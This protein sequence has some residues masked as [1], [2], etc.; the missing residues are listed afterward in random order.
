MIQIFLVQIFLYHSFTD[1][2]FLSRVRLGQSAAYFFSIDSDNAAFLAR[3][4]R[5]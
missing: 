2:K 3:I 5:R 4:N 1:F